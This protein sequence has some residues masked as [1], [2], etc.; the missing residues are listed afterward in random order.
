MFLTAFAYWLVGMPLGWWMTFHQGFGARGMWMGLIA[1]LS[2][3][4]VLLMLRFAWMRCCAVR[5][6]G[7]T[8]HRQRVCEPVYSKPSRNTGSLR[9]LSLS[10]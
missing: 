3:A 6:C 10:R 8:C 9:V 2:A 7:G 1:G 5:G 4:A